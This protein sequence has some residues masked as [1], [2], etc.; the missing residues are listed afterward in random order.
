MTPPKQC[1]ST[2]GRIEYFQCELCDGHD[3]KHSITWNNEL[4]DLFDFSKL[5]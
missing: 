3:G 2:L 4:S 5:E 1:K